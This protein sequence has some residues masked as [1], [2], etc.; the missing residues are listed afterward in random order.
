MP[1][2]DS[3]SFVLIARARIPISLSVRLALSSS[4]VDDSTKGLVLRCR[5]LSCPICE[6]DVD[7]HANSYK[8]NCCQH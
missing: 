3:L 7:L 1:S 4:R 8:E 2:C 6:K 5:L